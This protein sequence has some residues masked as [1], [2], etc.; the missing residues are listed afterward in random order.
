MQSRFENSSTD[1]CIKNNK[2]FFLCEK[3]KKVVEKSEIKD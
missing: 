2:F 1:L 3:L